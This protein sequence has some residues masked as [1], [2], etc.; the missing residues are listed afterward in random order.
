MQ[1]SNH[2]NNENV[3]ENE[4]EWIDSLFNC[5][6]QIIPSLVMSLYCPCVV[7]GQISEA[8]HLAPCACVCSGYSLLLLIFIVLSAYS[9][10]GILILWISSAI[11]ICIIRQQVRKY[12]KIKQKSIEDFLIS[13]FCSCCALSQVI[14]LF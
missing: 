13:C 7:M 8:I 12:Y 14:N 3:N 1:L 2:L 11:F 10:L 9:Y 5:F 4:N 6:T